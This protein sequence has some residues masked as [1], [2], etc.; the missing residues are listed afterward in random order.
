MTDQPSRKLEFLHANGFPGGSYRQLFQNFED[1]DVHFVESLGQFEGGLPQD[2]E[3]IADQ[4]LSQMNSHQP[5][6]GVGHSL[7]AVVLLYAAAQ[8]PEAFTDIILLDPPLFSWGKRASLW[9]LKQFGKMD[10]VTP[11]RTVLR[12]RETFSSHQEAFD[13]LRKRSFFRKFSDE[14]L[15]DYVS[16]GF[17]A[18]VD[19]VKLRIPKEL[20]YH[21]FQTIPLRF[22]KSW[23][24]LKGHLVFASDKGVLQ[25]SD[26]N[27]LRRALPGFQQTALNGGH[28]FPLEQPEKTAE[29][30]RT[31]INSRN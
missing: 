14:V 22:S 26:R 18:Q 7:G 30:I 11:A 31:L 20:E 6:V 3:S 9:L 28:M 16:K 23:K 17:I 21:I 12:R 13:Q 5:S 8:R 2:W 27:E 19:C 4:V 15:T 24:G 10:R 1:F 29:L 25:Q